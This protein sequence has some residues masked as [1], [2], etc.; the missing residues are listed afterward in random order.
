ML[1]TVGRAAGFLF[2]SATLSIMQQSGKCSLAEV[3][4]RGA[5]RQDPSCAQS[6]WE[7]R[8]GWM[9]TDQFCSSRDLK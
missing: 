1:Y 5:R 8:I 4:E 9:S 2:L 3:G 6:W 7:P